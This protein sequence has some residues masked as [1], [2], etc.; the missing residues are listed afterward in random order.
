MPDR[1]YRSPREALDGVLF[2]GMTIM[3]GG[4][5]LSGN[6]ESLIAEIRTAG[7]KD[8]TLISNN[9][10]A[11]GFGLGGARSEAARIGGVG[12]QRR[13]P[14]RVGNNRP[15]D[16]VDHSKHRL[17]GGAKV[18]YPNF[19]RYLRP[20]EQND[21]NIFQRFWGA[22]SFEPP[23]DGGGESDGAEEGM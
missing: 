23:C 8:L 12:L 16:P 11:D 7:V 5:G 13:Q 22:D 15:L 1:I 17:A 18:P 14:M 20:P 10:G 19:H 3:S 4:F 6:P 2:D 9:A 21:R